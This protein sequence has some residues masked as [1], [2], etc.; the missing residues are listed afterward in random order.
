[1]GSPSDRRLLVAS[2][3]SGSGFDEFYRRH[4]DAVL[5]FHAARVREPE[6]AAD[7]TGETFAAAL[8]AVHDLERELPREPV[9][10]LFTI[11]QRK[12]I[13]SYR[14][15]RVEDEARRRLA[16]ERIELGDEDLERVAE[17]ARTTD[18]LEHL[19]SVLPHDQFV[20]LRAR[21]IDGREYPDIASE[22]DCSPVVV[23]MRVSRAL[24]TLR[25]AGLEEL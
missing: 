21:V 11:A 9:A 1:M 20:A 14:R 5:S 23:R 7:L 10:W 8:L 6:L 17:V 4:R 19:E 25:N 16:F 18:L 12:L 24:K 3:K 13:D 2:R 15:G 22:L